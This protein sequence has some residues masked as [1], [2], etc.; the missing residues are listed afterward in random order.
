MPAESKGLLF[1]S[2]EGLTEGR[3]QSL[4]KP[5]LVQVKLVPDFLTHICLPPWVQPCSPLGPEWLLLRAAAHPG[6]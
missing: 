6:S 4:P 5:L 3:A 2:C 1:C